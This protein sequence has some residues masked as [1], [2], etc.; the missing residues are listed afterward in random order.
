[1]PLFIITMACWSTRCTAGR[2]C[3]VRCG[4]PD[5]SL[6]QP[7]REASCKA[8][9]R[10]PHGSPTSPSPG[11]T[12]SNVASHRVLDDRFAG[13]GL[14]E[15]GHA[16]PFRAPVPDRVLVDKSRHLL[17]HVPPRGPRDGETAADDPRCALLA[18]SEEFQSPR[19]VIFA[20]VG[21]DAK[22]GT[23]LL[24]TSSESRDAVT[25]G[26]LLIDR[27]SDLELDVVVRKLSAEPLQERAES[28]G[29][30]EPKGPSRLE[31]ALAPSPSRVGGRVLDESSGSGYLSPDPR[32]EPKGTQVR[33]AGPLAPG[34]VP[35]PAA[36]PLA[37][38]AALAV[39]T[40]LAPA[41]AMDG[42]GV[43]AAAIAA[44]AVVTV[45]ARGHRRAV[46]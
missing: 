1:M 7:S 33:G 30:G 41:T 39:W 23:L 11:G 24:C 26:V 31:A 12:L 17:Q 44:A 19:R 10:S 28:I 13:D 4:L 46:R 40:A 27:P 25:V 5:A 32:H 43:L 15:R 21:M 6:D 16:A 3:T 18:D 37:P 35:V 38:V 22:D 36:V 9:Q 2:P 42:R 29:V 20:S 8:C 14:D 45:R 34:T